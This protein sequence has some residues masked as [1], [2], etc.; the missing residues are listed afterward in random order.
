MDK[1]SSGTRRKRTSDSAKLIVAGATKAMEVRSRRI[2]RS[3]TEVEKVKEGNS[4]VRA[5]SL[6]FASC[7][8]EPS[9]MNLLSRV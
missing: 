6:S 8:R 3:R 9:Q 7:C 4:A 1:C 5:D 2:P